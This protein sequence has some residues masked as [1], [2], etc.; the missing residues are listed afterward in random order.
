MIRQQSTSARP[1]SAN[2]RGAIG[3]ILV[4]SMVVGSLLVA[5][6]IVVSASEQGV[7]VERLNSARAL[8][9]AEAGI[10]MAMREIFQNTDADGDGTIGTISNDS[11][12]ATDPA[13]GIARVVVT[14][15]VGSPQ[16]TYTSAGRCGNTRRFATADVEMP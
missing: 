16:T 8:Y 11:N 6:V 5:S 14:R 2:R 9:A 7:G 1:R 10:N 3:I 12:D 13:L 4:M 15:V